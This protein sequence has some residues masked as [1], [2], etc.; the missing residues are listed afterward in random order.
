MVVPNPYRGDKFYSAEN[1]GYEGLGRTWTPENRVIWFINL[2]R[3]ATIRIM[4]LVGERITEILHDDDYRALY[5]RPSGQE[6]FRLLSESGRELASGI[7]LYTVDY[8]GAT[9]TG[10]FVIIK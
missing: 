8:A 4:S 9:Q 6:E 2:P 10:K 1:G 7:Y 5:G 3:K